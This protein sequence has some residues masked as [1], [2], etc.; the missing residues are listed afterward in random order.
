M[1][2]NLKEKERLKDENIQQKTECLNTIFNLYLK[3]QKKKK[4]EFLNKRIVKI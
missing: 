3:I 2:K 4:S 1:L